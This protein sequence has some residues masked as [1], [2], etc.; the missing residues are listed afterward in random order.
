MNLHYVVLEYSKKNVHYKVG[1]NLKIL[2]FHGSSYLASKTN[3]L[4]GSFLIMKVE[5]DL[6]M[7]RQFLFNLKSY[8]N[9]GCKRSSTITFCDGFCALLF[10]FTGRG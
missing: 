3:V 1:I 4:N 6:I 5:Q 7:I 10:F 9:I 2:N 8:C